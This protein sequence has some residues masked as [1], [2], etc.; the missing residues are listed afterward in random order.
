MMKKRFLRLSAGLVAGVALFIAGVWGL[1]KALGTP[2]SKYRGQPTEYWVVQLN[3]PDATASNAAVAVLE[4]EI[5]PHLTNVMFN[6]THDSAFKLWLVDALDGLPGII[7]D[8]EPAYVRRKAAAYELGE[9]GPAARKAVPPLLQA[10]VSDDEAVRETAARSLGA[11]NADPEEVIPILTRYLMDDNV[12]FMAATALGQY[13]APA[14]AAVPALVRM[15]Q[16]GDAGAKVAASGALKLID[17]AAYAE[18]MKSNSTKT[19]GAGQGGS[20][21]VQAGEQPAVPPGSPK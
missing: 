18:M 10:F 8:F 17:A 1:S 2:L 7:V 20:V 13:G 14:R 11:I 6:D 9:Y 3:S 21:E 4:N 19:N 5:I 12:N 15:W 16:R